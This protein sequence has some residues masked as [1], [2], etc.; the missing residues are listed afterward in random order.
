MKTQTAHDQSRDKQNTSE[1]VVQRRA[2]ELFVARGQE[3]G[4]ELEDWL[5]AEEEI[6]QGRKQNFHAQK[7]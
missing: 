6:R 3:P 5:Q 4:H 1:E 7:L 2:Y